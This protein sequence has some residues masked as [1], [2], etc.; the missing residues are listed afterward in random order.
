MISL[1]TFGKL[2]TVQ[3]FNNFQGGNMPDISIIN[4]ALSFGLVALC[5]AAIV[6]VIKKFSKS[7]S[8]DNHSIDLEIL[9]R[10]SLSPKSHIFVIKAG[11]KTLLIG[12]AEQNIST[13]A[14]LTF[15]N[16]P[17]P[18]LLPAYQQ[19][20]K[21]N[22]QQNQVIK[23]SNNNLV[24]TVNNIDYDGDDTSFKAFLKSRFKRA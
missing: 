22:T 2:K 7:A 23:K 3:K 11:H 1:F 19:T 6:F 13:L 8:K 17:N 16:V 5:L 15:D 24:R 4:V 18:Q 14:D 21:Q 10:K 12:A 9:S 20:L